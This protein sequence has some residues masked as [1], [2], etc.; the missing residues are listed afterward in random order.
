MA[1]VFR[2]QTPAFFLKFFEHVTV[3]DFRALKRN[4][5]LFQ[6]Q[7]Q[8]HVTHQCA[9]STTAQLS[10]AQ[11]FT[12]NDKQDLVTVHFLTQVIHHDQAVAV[13]VKCQANVRA[14][15]KNTFL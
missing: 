9:D 2:T 10:L 5:Q 6:C 7:L 15:S 8:P 12:G 1:G 14:F 3:A 13:T 11:C 4:T